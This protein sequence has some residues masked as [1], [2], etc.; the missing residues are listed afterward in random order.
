L[1]PLLPFIVMVLASTWPA[2]QAIATA[3][4]HTGVRNM[5]FL[6]KK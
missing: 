3:A 6:L 2:A 5:E 4:K 1:A